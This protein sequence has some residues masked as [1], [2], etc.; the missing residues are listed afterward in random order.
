MVIV[1]T[2]VSVGFDVEVVLGIVVIVGFGVSVIL[3][4]GV[5]ASAFSVTTG[6]CVGKG[7]IVIKGFSVGTIVTDIIGSAGGSCFFVSRLSSVLTVSV[8]EGS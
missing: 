1:G 2:G 4:M 8:T 5:T 7:V 6:F 3:G